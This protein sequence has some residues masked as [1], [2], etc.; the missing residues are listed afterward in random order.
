MDWLNYLLINAAVLNVD[1]GVL[2]HELIHC[3]NYEGD[4][5][6]LFDRN[7]HDSDPKSVMRPVPITG[8]PI[9]MAEKHAR[10]LRAAYFARAV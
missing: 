2:L 1:R 7:Q 4:I 6:P 9:E 3:A 8:V 5:D 10:K